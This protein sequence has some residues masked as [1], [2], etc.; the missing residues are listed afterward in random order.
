MGLGVALTGFL[1]GFAKEASSQIKSRN[2]KLQENIDRQIELHKKEVADS[3]EKRDKER[4]DMM[5]RNGRL[6]SMFDDVDLDIAQRA[7]VIQDDA[8][9]NRFFTYYEK[10]QKDPKRMQELKNSISVKNNVKFDNIKDAVMQTT[11][12][13][14]LT[15]PV[16]VGTKTAFG[17]PSN[18]QSEQLEQYEATLP[19]SIKDKKSKVRLT[20][21]LKSLRERAAP[22]KAKNVAK[23]LANE[24]GNTLQIT[25]QNNSTFKN[26]VLVNI[27][28]TDY[29]DA[30]ITLLDKATPELRDLT[31]AETIS[32]IKNNLNNMGETINIETIRGYKKVLSGL[33]I[34]PKLL[35]TFDFA[36]T[37]K[38]DVVKVI[39]QISKDI[40]SVEKA[41]IAIGVAVEKKKTMENL[42]SGGARLDNRTSTNRKAREARMAELLTIIQDPTTSDND[43]GR[44]TLELIRLEEK[45]K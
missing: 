8:T 40:P 28:D 45:N 29:D 24:I 44:A 27:K 12:V 11:E 30:E 26:K 17:I 5:L 41:K 10:A 16:V 18:I 38:E 13:E 35:N 33:G 6:S 14:K 36:N 20:G 43:K 32:A 22:Q 34:S 2:E 15:K 19:T 23:D 21:G 7:Y 31:Q 9:A 3:V 37:P 42:G 25:M 4:E 1:T 39:E